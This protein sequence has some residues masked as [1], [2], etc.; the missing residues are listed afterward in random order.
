MAKSPEEL[1]ESMKKGLLEK[2]AHPLDHWADLVRKSGLEKFGDQ[3][4]LLKGEHGLTHGYANLVCQAAKGRLDAD[5]GDL[6]ESQY[7]G[8]EDLRPIYDALVTHASSLGDDVQMAPKKTSVAFRRSKNFAVVTPATRT[9]IDL[10]LNLKGLPGTDRLLEE[11]PGG[12][13]T[14]KVRLTSVADV[15]AELKAWL[16]EAYTQA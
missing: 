4:K 12:M 3:M 13:C 6:L 7:K 9:R 2:T 15:D 8:K 1:L 14:H 16:A 11:K 5:E 10:G